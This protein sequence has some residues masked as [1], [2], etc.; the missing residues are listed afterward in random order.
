V[1]SAPDQSLAPVAALDAS[2][3]SFIAFAR[4]S[5]AFIVMLSHLRGVMLIGWGSL[6]SGLHNPFVAGFYFATSFY[7]EAVVV[8]F[9]LSG[10]LIA[11]PNL[12]RVRIRSF[13]PKSYA[14]DR[15]T[16]IYVT[17]LPA[18]LL[19]LAADAIGRH[20][21]P[22]AGFY[23]GS[24]LLLADR[25][26][27]G[28]KDDGWL[29]FVRNLL[30]LQPVHAPMLGSN[31]PLWSL[32]YE[33]WFYVWFG[34]TAYA[35]QVRTRST[36]L[37]IGLA[38]FGL[39]LFHWTAIFYVAIWC[40]GALA[41]QW[42]RWPRSITLAL[43]AFAL[44]LA[45]SM[46]G[47]AAGDIPNVP[48]KWT[49]LPVGLAF[50]WLVALMKRRSYRIWNSSEKFNQSL[51]NFSYS[52]YVIHYPLLLCFVSLY[53]TLG[54]VTEV[55]RGLLPDGVGLAVYGLVAAS[56]VLSAFIFSRI[57]EARTGAARRWIKSRV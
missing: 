10:F 33:V 20:F 25:V 16:R 18:L 55:K 39:L 53:T 6:P 41:Y 32:S 15:F 57:F 35:L 12:D 47:R 9:V 13:S 27:G 38:T 52:L 46:S 45:L 26:V 56:T 28:I 3:R 48:L 7:H 44:T 1:S 50:A 21:L 51:S 2:G 54:D 49:D 29:D 4:W 19:T 42:S 36:P 37:L 11:G 31:K 43:I 5:S 14:V 30:M 23:D 24:N 40:F 34:I 8:F 17:A 22:G